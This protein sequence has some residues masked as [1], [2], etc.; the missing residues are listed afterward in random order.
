MTTIS[1]R[2]TLLNMLVGAFALLVAAGAFVTYDQITFQRNLERTLSAQARIIAANTVT[3]ITFNDPQAAET[4]LS[5]LQNSEDI[6]SAGI[7]TWPDEKNFAEFSRDKSQHILKFPAITTGETEAVTYDGDRV[8]LVR[9]ITLGDKQIGIVHLQADASQLNKRLFQ[10]SGI[11]LLVLVC[12]LALALLLSTGVR[13]SVTDP[14][15]GLA[16]VARIVSTERDYS[17]RATGVTEPAELAALVASFN[18]MLSQ[19]EL[20]DTALRNAQG[21]LENKVQDRTRQL[22]AANQELETFSYSVSHDLRNPLDAIKGLIYILTVEYGEK[23]DAQGLEHLRQMRISATRMAEL[24]EDLLNLA[25]VNTTAVHPERLDLRELA[26]EMAESLVRREPHRKVTF[27]AHQPCEIVEADRRLMRIVLDNL[28]SNAWKY[29]LN[30]KEARIE[31]GCEQRGGRAVFYVR[32]NGAGFDP[33]LSDR[34]FK[35]FQR[36]HSTAEF[37]GTGIGLATVQRIITRHGGDIWAQGAEGTGATFYF[38]IGRLTTSRIG[39][40]HERAAEK[41]STI[42]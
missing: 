15:V 23:L 20:R 13:R 26:V 38:S 34:L 17:V 36:L 14:I 7:R 25:R 22:I 5:A 2:V 27:I 18:D 1:R 32:D 10:Y 6:L 11:A 24:I 31:F 39:D 19:I 33:Q 42:H 37:P 29:T 16:R 41:S 4:T 8:V 35:P 3:A 21:E 40:L 12:S 28:L 9:A 30:Q